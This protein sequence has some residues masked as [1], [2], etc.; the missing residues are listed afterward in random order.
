MSPR[1]MECSRKRTL[2]ARLFPIS[3]PKQTPGPFR[4]KKGKPVSHPCPFSALVAEE[5]PAEALVMAISETS[6]DPHVKYF[7]FWQIILFFFFFLSF[8]LQLISRTR[9][10]V[11]LR[12][13]LSFYSQEPTAFPTV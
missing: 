7:L 2:V 9:S 1:Q 8:F 5:L 3:P 12:A 10:I 6:C 11:P 13:H 4:S